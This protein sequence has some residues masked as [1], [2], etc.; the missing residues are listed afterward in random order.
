MMDKNQTTQM[1]P[2]NDACQRILDEHPDAIGVAYKI[3]DCGCAWMCGVSAKGDPVGRL[4]HV[5]GQSLKKGRKPPICLRCKKE[6]GLDRIVWEGLYWP[7]TQQEWPDKDLR[8]AIGQSVFGPDY[9]EP[10]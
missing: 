8:E 10:E 2:F 5:S 1:T 9:I 3:L 4:L 7:G 6:D